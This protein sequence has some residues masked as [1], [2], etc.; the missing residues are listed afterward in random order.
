MH[1]I[2]TSV[3]TC[4]G[5]TFQSC[6]LRT[7]VVQRLGSSIGNSH[8]A[9]GIGPD[10]PFSGRKYPQLAP[11]VRALCAVAGRCWSPVAAAVAVTVAVSS[12]QVVRGPR[13]SR[14]VAGPPL[15]H[16][17]ICQGIEHLAEMLE[18]PEMALAVTQDEPRPGQVLRQPQPMGGR[19]QAVLAAVPQ[20]DRAGDGAQVDVP[21]T[22]PGDVIPA[23]NPSRMVSANAAANR[24]SPMLIVPG[25]K[26]LLERRHDPGVIGG[27][28]HSASGSIPAANAA[29][30]PAGSPGSN[31]TAVRSLSSS[32]P[33]APG[34]RWNGPAPEA[35]PTRLTRPPGTAAAASAPGP[36]PD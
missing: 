7:G 25:R 19:R 5:P 33:R 12:A 4:A 26:Q 1:V 18:D 17:W 22:D 13:R 27:A 14:A 9:R 36:P 21:F 10:R 15:G 35:I 28:E 23:S 2:Y 30:A 32:W 34:T 20:Q 24:G 6:P 31:A 29:A 11:I 3:D 8:C 16:I